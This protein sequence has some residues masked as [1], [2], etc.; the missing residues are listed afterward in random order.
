MYPKISIVTPSFNQGAFIEQTIQSVLNQNYPNLEYIIIDG[1]STDGTV[2]IIKK[3]AANLTWWVSEKDR[4]QADAINKGLQHCTGEI[5][6]FIN[7]DDYLADGA[8]FKI[9]EGFKDKKTGI[10]AGAV[11]NFNETGLTELWVNKN[12]VLEQFF[13][14]DCKVVYHQPGVWLKM[15]ILNKAGHFNIGYHYCF[16][17]EHLL[18]Y[19]LHNNEVCYLPDVLAY[20]RMHEDSKTVSQL[21]NFLWDFNKMYKMFW[22]SHKGTPLS[23]LVKRMSRDYEWPLLV[24]SVNKADRGRLK[25]F[26]IASRAIMQDP[27]KRLNKKSMG[28][29]KH[30]LMGPKTNK[31]ANE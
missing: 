3:Y 26:M 29:L 31:G 23:N 5:F 10:V 27:Q 18:R 7:S 21:E 12:F 20:F 22:K 30:I 4:G 11:W 14:I 19:L 25:N 16:D 1:G 9:A 6:N 15:D 24:C 2:D 13:E 17:Q 28:W 8:L